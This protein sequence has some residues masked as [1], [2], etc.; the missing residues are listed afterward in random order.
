M[1]MVWEGGKADVAAAAAHA[2]LSTHAVRCALL[3]PH[4]IRFYDEQRQVLLTG[5]RARNIH[6]LK[7]LRDQDENRTAAVQAVDRLEEAA[8]NR[9]SKG[10]NAV[11]RSPGIVI[12][13]AGR[14]PQMKVDGSVIEMNA[15]G[16]AEDDN[17]P[18]DA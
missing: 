12:V 9:R 2:G 17:G 5:E 8:E 16:S 7:E 13:I 3:K 6:R 4:V 14:D 15:S 10:G 11:N 18:D 1:F